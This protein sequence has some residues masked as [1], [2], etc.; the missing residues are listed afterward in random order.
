MTLPFPTDSE[1]FYTGLEERD[2]TPNK[3]YAVLHKPETH[4]CITTHWDR[5]Y[6]AGFAEEWSGLLCDPDEVAYLAA[7]GYKFRIPEHIED[8]LDQGYVLETSKRWYRRD[9]D[10]D[11]T[12][13]PAP[14]GWTGPWAE[15][16]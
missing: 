9:A 2:R 4:A 15:V 16:L 13:R 11:G 6:V 3:I 10:E 5:G 1:G 7:R 14:E 8:F 12:L